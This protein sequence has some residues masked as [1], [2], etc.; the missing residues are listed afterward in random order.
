MSANTDRDLMQQALDALEEIALAGMSGTGQESKEAMTEWHARQAWKF[1][2]IA[3]R[4]LDPLRARLSEP[5]Q[6]VDEQPC[7]CPSG[8]GSLRWPC[9]AHPVAVPEG[10]ALVPVEPTDAMVEAGAIAYE[11]SGYHDLIGPIAVAYRA[12]IAA[13]QKG[14]A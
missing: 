11:Q 12:M 10:W 5:V 7:T 14:A 1:I 13:E 2:G 8:D 6:P 9:P 4:A 3:A